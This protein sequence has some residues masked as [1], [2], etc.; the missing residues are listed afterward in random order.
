MSHCAACLEPSLPLRPIILDG[1]RHLACAPCRRAIPKLRAGKPV[2]APVKA[3]LLKPGSDSDRQWFLD[4]HGRDHRIREPLGGETLV[5][6][7]PA[8]DRRLI[9]VRQI[10][11]GVRLKASLDWPAELP[12]PLNSEAAARALYDVAAARH[13]KLAQIEASLRERA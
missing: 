2:R 7:P 1:R 4:H 5:F 6:R 8:G 11:P 9:V 13:P 12:P 3:R 10:E